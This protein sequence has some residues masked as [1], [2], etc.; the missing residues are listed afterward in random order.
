MSE[1]PNSRTPVRATFRIKF[2][3]ET[4]PIATVRQAHRFI[5]N[6]SSIELM[7]SRSLQGRCCSLSARSLRQRDVDRAGDKCSAGAVRPRQRCCSL[8]R[9]K[10]LNIQVVQ[11]ARSTERPR[12][13]NVRPA[14]VSVLAK[15]SSVIAGNRA[16]MDLRRIADCL[17]GAWNCE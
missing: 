15:N 16:A 17:W 11:F 2:N 8:L 4:A 1:A 12:C 5:T 9:G 14:K 3:G 6:L 13:S 10:Q 7:E